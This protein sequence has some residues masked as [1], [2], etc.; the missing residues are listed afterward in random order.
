MRQLQN[1]K[2]QVL[3]KQEAATNA[4]TLTSD[5]LDCRGF[6]EL[7]LI[8]H[9]TTSN[10][11]TNNPSVLKVQESDDT[12]SSNFA[13]VSGLVGD[14]DFTIPAEPTATTNNAKALINVNLQGRKRYLRVLISPVTT[15]TFSVLGVLSKASEA[16][17]SATEQGA[18]VVVT[19]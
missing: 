8:V 19:A 7:L 6:D 13:N 11:A 10:D 2:V 16:P 18:A 5:N 12:V 4:A 3:I 14:T 15:Q 1:A 17:N 9:G